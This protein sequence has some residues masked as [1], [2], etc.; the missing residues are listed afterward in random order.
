[1]KKKT[2]VS[3]IIIACIALIGVLGYL[4]IGNPIMFINNQKLKNSVQSIDSET[5]QLNDVVP[6]EWDFLYTFDPYQSK[7]EIEKIVRFKSADI[8][9]NNINE[10]MVHLLFVKG[11]KVVASI[12]GYGSNLGYNIDFTSKEEQNVTFVEDA[13]FNVTRADGI[14]TL[15]YAK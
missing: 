7:E 1:M 5:V 15:I 2:K 13:Q 6:F 8:K 12:L 9:E 4:L 3:I 11:D 10:G 14:I